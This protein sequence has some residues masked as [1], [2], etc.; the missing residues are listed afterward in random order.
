MNGGNIV[1]PVNLTA[2]GNPYSG[3][4]VNMTFDSSALAYVSGVDGGAL[5]SAGAQTFCASA[6]NLTS[7]AVMGCTVL[8]STNFPTTSGVLARITLKPLHANGCVV[9]HLVSVGAPDNAGQDGTFTLVAANGIPSVEHN[10]YGPDVSVNLADGG[11]C[12]A[13]P[14]QTPTTVATSTAVA[15]AT[16]TA[17]ALRPAT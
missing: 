9:L 4:Q 2:A 8:G 5:G 13:A 1:V 11:V 14:T 6:P 12:G 16:A 7:P 15:T 10:T 3:F 17:T